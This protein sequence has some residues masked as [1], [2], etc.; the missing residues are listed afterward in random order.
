[1]SERKHAEKGPRSP[2]PPAWPDVTDQIVLAAI[3]AVP[4]H[5]FV[6]SVDL[7]DAYQDAPQ[8][9]G[10]GQTISQPHIVALMTQALCL[11]A[12]SRVLEVGTGSGYQAAVLAQI[13]PHVWSVEAR[14]ELAGRA[15]TVLRELGYP[16]QVKLG[17]GRL[18]WPENAPY[19]AI[20]VT[21]AGREVPPALAIQLAE[22][23]RLIIPLGSGYDGQMLWL[24]RKSDG[25]LS[26]HMLYAV[27]FVPLV[28]DA[29]PDAA[30]AEAAE[31]PALADVRRQLHD[32][33]EPWRN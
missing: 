5:L 23:G 29:V 14:P 28:E 8:P 10:Y 3:A 7:D 25:K 20:I 21:A 11:G 22:G 1:M 18:G 32:L 15:R 4:R 17:D 30:A 6:P 24:I 12:G 9:I 33:F 31:D 16:V 27:C 13:T 19:D 26:L 2:W